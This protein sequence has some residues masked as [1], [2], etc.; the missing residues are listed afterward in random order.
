MRPYHYPYFYKNEIEK[1]VQELSHSGVIRPNQSPYSSLVLLVRK[2]DGSWKLCVDYWGLNAITIN[3]K[4]SIPIVEELMGELH[5]FK[6][7]F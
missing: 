1:I 3:D 5:G 4:F 2:A 6:V 7:F